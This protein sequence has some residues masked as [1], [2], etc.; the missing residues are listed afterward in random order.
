MRYLTAV[1]GE[2]LQGFPDNWT[3]GVSNVERWFAI[4]NAVNCKV[5]EY[6]F[7]DYLKGLWW[8][9]LTGQEAIKL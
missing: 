9:I 4:G 2:R 7:I 6:L 3:E 5:S 8:E 1:E